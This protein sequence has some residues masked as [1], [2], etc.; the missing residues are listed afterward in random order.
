MEF[1]GSKQG[2]RSKFDRSRRS[3]RRERDKFRRGS[4]TAK[5]KS[6][7]ED[8]DD[9]PHLEEGSQSEPEYETFDGLFSP[10]RVPRKGSASSAIPIYP[11]ASRR[12][13]TSSVDSEEVRVRFRLLFFA[14]IFVYG[15]LFW[16]YFLNSTIPVWS[17]SIIPL[18][19]SSAS[20]HFTLRFCAFRN[21]SS[22][23]ICGAASQISCGV[24]LEQRRRGSCRS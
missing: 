4:D 9:D 17:I 20:N 8:S 11:K 2:S 15:F 1:L 5:E 10:Q 21:R 3:K 19:P 6:R 22:K 24:S 13:M 16:L 7:F 23:A 14:T 18:F 12:F